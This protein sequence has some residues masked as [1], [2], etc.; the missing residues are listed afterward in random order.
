[1]DGFGNNLA[2]VFGTFFDIVEPVL[3][4]RDAL[5][6]GGDDQMAQLFV[7]VVVVRRFFLSLRHRGA[8]LRLLGHREGRTCCSGFGVQARSI[9]TRL[10]ATLPAARIYSS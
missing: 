3:D 9:S 6:F 10:F 8:A 4:R 7:C 5:L 1:M 2:D